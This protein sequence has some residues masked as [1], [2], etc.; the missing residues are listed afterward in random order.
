MIFDYSSFLIGAIIAVIELSCILQRVAGSC[1]RSVLNYF[2]SSNPRP[3]QE[4]LEAFCER[5]CEETTA[6][7]RR[8]SKCSH[9]YPV[10]WRK[11]KKKG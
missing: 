3:F 2:T 11:K 1:S 9:I 7:R 8:R 6:K 4:T 10:I 5:Y